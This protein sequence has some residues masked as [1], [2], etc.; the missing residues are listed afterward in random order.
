MNS[1]IDPDTAAKTDLILF[2]TGNSP[3]S[4]RARA[5]LSKALE[6]ITHGRLSVRHM[7]LLE[8]TDGIT[9]YGLFATPALIHIRDNGEPAVLYGDLSSEPELQRFLANLDNRVTA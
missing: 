6:T 8:D 1:G 9:E 5:N 7:D 4:Q 2:V 3:R